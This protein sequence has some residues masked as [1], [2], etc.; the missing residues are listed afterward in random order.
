MAAIMGY[1]IVFEG[2]EG[3][4]KTTQIS[5]LGEYLNKK[6]LPVIIT[7]EPGGTVI[8]DEIRKILLSTK[9]AGIAPETELLLYTASRVQHLQQLITPALNVGTTV[10]CD[11]FFDA[12]VAYQ[13]YGEGIDLALIRQIQKT[14]FSYIIPD[15]T[16][17]LD[18]PVDLGLGRS[19]L[20]IKSEGKES[21]EGRFEEKELIFHERVRSGYLEL[22]RMEPKRFCIINGEQEVAAVHQ[23]ICAAVEQGLKEKGYAI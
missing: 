1:F 12:T 20:R 14:F 7:R 21:A 10:L 15:L 3:C 18:C 4:G 13:G 6:G 5:L 2:I 23:K 8:G 11:R 16:I 19:R 22:A 17:L 9:N